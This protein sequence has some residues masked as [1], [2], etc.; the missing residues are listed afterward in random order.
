MASCFKVTKFYAILQIASRIPADLAN[1]SYLYK[2][3][4][5]RIAGG[6]MEQAAILQLAR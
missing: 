3:E 1:G 2:I 5:E 6:A 4:A